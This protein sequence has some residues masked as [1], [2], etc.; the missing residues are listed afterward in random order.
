MTLSNLAAATGVLKEEVENYKKYM[1]EREEIRTAEEQLLE[2]I[3][4][5]EQ[6]T[7]GYE[8]FAGKVQQVLTEQL[9]QPELSRIQ[10]KEMQNLWK[11][12]RLNASLA[13]EDCY[14]LPIH[15]GE[16][17]AMVN[18]RIRHGQEVAS[19][20]ISM[21]AGAYGRLEAV[22]EEREEGALQGALYCER[23]SAD[24]AGLLEQVKND[25]QEKAVT[26]N[27]SDINIEIKQGEKSDP[28]KHTISSE[29]HISSRE[30]FQMAK[31]FIQSIRNNM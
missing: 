1:G 30:L 25:L 24:S 6:L 8:D 5:D 14:Q 29:K 22:F 19:A 15:L 17:V 3:T 11:Q 28:E 18:L 31:I 7:E 9:Y 27:V 26:V 16:E 4:D 13:R 10:I 12:V 20:E 21:D 2:Q 23:L